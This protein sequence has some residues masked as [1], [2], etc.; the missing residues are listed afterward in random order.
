MFL[1]EIIFDVH[2]SSSHNIV[3]YHLL[4]TRSVTKAPHRLSLYDLVD[5]SI[6]CCICSLS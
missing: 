4:A 5:D 6:H 1:L 2:H 3:P